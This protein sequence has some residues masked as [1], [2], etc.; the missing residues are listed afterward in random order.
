[1]A[2]IVHFVRHA[3]VCFWPS[4]NFVQSLNLLLTGLPQP[5]NRK[6]RPPRPRTHTARRATMR[7][8]QGSLPLPLSNRLGSC[9][10]FAPNYQYRTTQLPARF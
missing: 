7:K 2:P 1:M 5:Y 6:P 3:Q 8:T 9:L 10:A 4:E